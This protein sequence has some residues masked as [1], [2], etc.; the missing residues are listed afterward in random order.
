M[1]APSTRGATCADSRGPGQSSL[2]LGA[3]CGLALSPAPSGNPSKSC[4][5]LH[6][7]EA[8]CAPWN[9]CGD[10]SGERS[11]LASPSGETESF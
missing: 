8:W 6:R 10:V 9:G 3:A 4:H 2:N 5:W 1:S 7:D 11:R